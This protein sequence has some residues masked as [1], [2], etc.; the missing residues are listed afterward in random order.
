MIAV[1][2]QSDRENALHNWLEQ[3]NEL[4]LENLSDPNLTNEEIAKKLEI[5]PRKLYRKIKEL[6][7]HTP[8]HYIR[9]IRLEKAHDLLSSGNYLTVKEVVPIVGFLKLE[10]FYRIFKEHHGYPPGEVL[11]RKGWK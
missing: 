5:S 4:L 11:R 3:F 9:N 8:N 10:Y 1:A 6:T 2:I 7:G